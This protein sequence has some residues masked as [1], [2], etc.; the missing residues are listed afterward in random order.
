[1][2]WQP[3]RPSRL[4]NKYV[5]VT[6][7]SAQ[8]PDTQPIR[9]KSS[10]EAL[11]AP[12][13]R[14]AKPADPCTMVIFGAGGDLTKRLLVPALYNLAHTGLLPKEFAL[15]GVGH[16]AKT[17]EQ[18]RDELYDM[19]KAFVGSGIDQQAWQ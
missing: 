4:G 5:R 19:L 3:A 18:W 14:D 6:F 11:D 17:T 15:I 16:S 13:R 8:M 1:M 7:F 9:V 10:S 2:A 12:P